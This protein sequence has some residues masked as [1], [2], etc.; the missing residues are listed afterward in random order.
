V[1]HHPQIVGL[2]GVALGVIGTAVLIGSAGD[3]TGTLLSGYAYGAASV[4]LAL[5]VFQ[6]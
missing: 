3:P 5:E 6:A 4:L 2:V 1:T